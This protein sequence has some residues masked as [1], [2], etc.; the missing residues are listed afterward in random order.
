[1]I[2]DMVAN[3][4]ILFNNFQKGINLGRAGEKLQISLTD[5]PIVQALHYCMNWKESGCEGK[6]K[7]TPQHTY[8]HSLT[9]Y[10]HFLIDISSRSTPPYFFIRRRHSIDI[11]LGVDCQYSVT[12]KFGQSVSNKASLQGQFIIIPWQS[13][14]LHITHI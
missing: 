9:H 14:H 1:M 6:A 13:Y 12:V 8:I 10:T 2:D 4:F 5:T 3:P 7:C 11:W